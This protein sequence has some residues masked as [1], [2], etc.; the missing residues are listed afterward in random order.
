MWLDTFLQAIFFFMCNVCVTDLILYNESKCNFYTFQ[1]GMYILLQI[2]VVRFL[3]NNQ[4]FTEYNDYDIVCQI[5]GLFLH[6]SLKRIP[7]FAR[8]NYTTCQLRFKYLNK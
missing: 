4:N 8:V 7:Y 3:H 5:T 6:T 2:F 1:L